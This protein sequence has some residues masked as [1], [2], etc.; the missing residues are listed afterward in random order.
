MSLLVYTGGEFVTQDTILVSNGVFLQPS[1]DTL[2]L[3]ISAIGML[4]RDFDGAL[5]IVSNHDT[6]L[7][8][9]C[10]PH[11][12]KSVGVVFEKGQVLL[13]S[14]GYS[15]DNAATSLEILLLLPELL[16]DSHC[17][18]LSPIILETVEKCIN[19]INP[20]IPNTTN[21]LA[22]RI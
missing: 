4:I 17:A 5:S 2:N 3:T 7:F 6:I 20:M 14:T 11:L 8:F 22:N 10:V 13:F 18:S 21:M 16:E 9:K 19:K 15:P 1:L 12:N